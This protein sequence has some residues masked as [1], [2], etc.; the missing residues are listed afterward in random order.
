MIR[1]PPFWA[2]F[3]T[4]LGV[5][6]LCGLGTWQLQRLE[7]KTEILAALESAKQR[8]G[9]PL[10]LS[11]QIDELSKAAHETDLI[12]YVFVEGRW[13]HDKEIAIGPRTWNGKP[14]Y[15]ILTPLR[16]DD[17]GI[18]LVNR[19]W[20]PQDKK[21]KASHVN[22]SA[23]IMGML[24]RPPPP[25]PFTPANNPDKNDWYRIDLAQIAA[26][27]N[28]ESLAPLVL[29]IHLDTDHPEWPMT[30]AL[31][32]KPPNDHLQYAVFWFAMAAI[33]V[34]VFGLRFLIRSRE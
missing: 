13:L 29:Y 31:E 33:L 32:W 7:W 15:H 26:A 34:V 12:R 18:L 5:C 6:I 3:F 14:G 21:D 11:P 4:L 2:G 25:N 28:L 27:R 8:S 20:V 17:G 23:R 19:G 22:N 1:R 10:F 30:E 16:L 24:R 9:V